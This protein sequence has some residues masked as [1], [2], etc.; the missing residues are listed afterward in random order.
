MTCLR[1]TQSSDR[2]ASSYSIPTIISCC[3]DGTVAVSSSHDQQRSRARFTH[4]RTQRG[5]TTF[6]NWTYK[7]LNL[8][9]A[10][11]SAGGASGVAAVP[12][13]IHARLARLMTC[14][15]SS[16]CARRR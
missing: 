12:P 11:S 15:S 1:W 16:G 8:S 2:A 14:T 9:R 6:R 4:Q 10:P 3:L 7:S 13:A 5:R